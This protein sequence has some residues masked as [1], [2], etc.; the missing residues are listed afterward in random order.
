MVKLCT[1]HLCSSI[2][3]L[4]VYVFNH[5]FGVLYCVAVLRVMQVTVISG[6]SFVCDVKLHQNL[7]ISVILQKNGIF[8]YST[9]KTE[10]RSIILFV[11]RLLK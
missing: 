2:T 11:I 6:I 1:N 3:V 10:N 4:T 8:S 7:G 9:A 5:F